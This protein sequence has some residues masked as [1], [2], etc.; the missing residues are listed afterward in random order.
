MEGKLHSN[1]T[2]ALTDLV[3]G[4]G[5]R[6]TF[7]LGPISFIFMQFSGIF[8]QNNRFAAPSLGYVAPTRGWDMMDLTRVCVFVAVFS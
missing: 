7:H 6:D 1:L 5:A 3:G 2:F 8:N 4:R